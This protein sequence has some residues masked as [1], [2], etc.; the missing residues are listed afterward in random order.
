MTTLCSELSNARSLLKIQNPEEVLPIGV[1]FLMFRPKNFL[2]S[3]VPVLHEYR[4][5]AVWLF[6]AENRAQYTN[7]IPLLKAEG[8]AWG[9]K[10]F[11]QVGSVKDAREAVEDGTDVLVVQG[12]DAGG[13]QLAR[14]AGLMALLPEVVDI[15]KEEFEDSQVSIIAAGGIMDGRGIAAAKALGRYTLTFIRSR[16]L[17]LATNGAIGAQGVVMGTRV[18][19]TNSDEANYFI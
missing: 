3:I 15:L 7:I 1:G 6:A 4:P 9:L 19:S 14:G 16:S 5:A 17:R 2:E 10:V 18:C 12:T 8:K 13:H 11:V